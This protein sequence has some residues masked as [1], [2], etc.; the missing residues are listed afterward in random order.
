MKE[1][2]PSRRKFLDLSWKLG[3]VVAS[4]LLLGK[5]DSAKLDEQS[6]DLE[7]Q[8]KKDYIEYLESLHLEYPLQQ[9]ISFDAQV[10]DLAEMTNQLLPVNVPDEN[11]FQSFVPSVARTEERFFERPQW[12]IE[13]LR[14]EVRRGPTDRPMVALTIDD[15][16]FA[17]HEILDIL[18][19]KKV[20]A[21]LFLTGR[22][23]DNDPEFLK[24]AVD[25]GFEI[26]NHTWGHANL[27]SLNSRQIEEQILGGERSFSKIFL[28]ATTS[29]Y[30]R[31]PYG[32]YDSNI[33]EIA[34]RLGFRLFL[35]TVSGDAGSMHAEQLLIWYLVRQIDNLKPNPWGAIILLHFTYK[36]AQFL[37]DLID[38]LVNER[39]L[40]L[41]SLSELYSGG[42]V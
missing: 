14:K 24:R 8:A 13:T 15:G 5:S 2:D 11:K 32:N 39:G 37:P 7:N 20:G 41:V 3:L 28:G 10:L 42:R 31:P 17:R 19:A 25:E 23:M 36:T 27:L 26:A 35:W 33:R 9:R 4:S 18:I 1:F 30:L 16:N 34:V 22:V 29:P 38:G 40:K 12:D 21:T 6:L